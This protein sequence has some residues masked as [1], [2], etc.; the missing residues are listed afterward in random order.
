M[1]K[2]KEGGSTVPQTRGLFGDVPWR[3]H[4]LRVQVPQLLSQQWLNQMFTM[5]MFN[6]SVMRSRSDSESSRSL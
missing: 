6:E 1:V 5:K 3:V 4:T 2:T